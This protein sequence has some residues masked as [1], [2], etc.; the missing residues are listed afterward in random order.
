MQKSR[1]TILTDAYKEILKD[2][3]DHGFKLAEYFHS[4]FVW[5]VTLS[6]GAIALI[7]SATDK[8]KHSFDITFCFLI[9]TIIFGIIARIL[10][11][12]ATLMGY[13]FFAP[14]ELKLKGIQ[15]NNNPKRLEG[16]ETSVDIFYLL[17]EGFEINM[18]SLLENKKIGSEDMWDAID[19]NARNL[20]TK[21]YLHSQESLE[22]AQID[23]TK[24]ITSTYGAKK[25]FMSNRTKNLVH[26]YL[27][28]LSYTIYFLSTLMFTYSVFSFATQYFKIR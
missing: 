15:L 22:K 20:Y 27:T 12:I 23:I 7:I 19:E 13:T 25:K 18:P 1:V 4:L 14:L 21:F 17:L 9:A 16:D 26:R 8:L 3:K 2:I 6:T 5:L 11:T 24:L 10:Y 28:F